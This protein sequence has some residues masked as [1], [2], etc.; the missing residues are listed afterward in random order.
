M[1]IVPFSLIVQYCTPI[2]M[3]GPPTINAKAHE[4]RHRLKFKLLIPSIKRQTSKDLKSFSEA[5]L[6][7]ERLLLVITYFSNSAPLRSRPSQPSL[8]SSN[9]Q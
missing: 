8:S 7:S 2:H 4:I 3:H 6:V 5:Y 1:Y 9:K